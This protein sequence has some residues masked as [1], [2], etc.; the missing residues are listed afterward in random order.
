MKR[1]S[2]IQALLGAIGVAAAGRH[3]QASRPAILLQESQ[4]A[5]FQYYRGETIWPALRVGQ[6][7]KLVREPANAFDRDAV[8]VYCHGDK[9]GFVPQL[10]NR[11]I[12]QM[13]D[14]GEQLDAQIAELDGEGHPWNRV[15]MSI[16]LASA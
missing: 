13:L 2:F 7:L 6:K 4:V 11:A 3:A 9:L 12:A 8:A 5:G 15:R 14:R 10:E 1:R 16:S